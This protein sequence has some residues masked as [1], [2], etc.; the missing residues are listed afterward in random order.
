MT[1]T[2]SFISSVG[3]KLQ[4]RYSYY[5]MTFP[6]LQAAI[7]RVW[8]GI[9]LESVEQARE[10]AAVTRMESGLCAFTH[11]NRKKYDTFRCVDSN[12]KMFVNGI[13]PLIKS[14]LN[15]TTSFH[16]EIKIPS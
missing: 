5:N 4:G 3:A 9:S 16:G 13:L 1:T 8:S 10:L 12:M 7:T 14:S 11:I 6:P 2:K 15:G